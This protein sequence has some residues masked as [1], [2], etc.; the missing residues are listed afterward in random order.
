MK[1]KSILLIVCLT[2]LAACN[3]ADRQQAGGAPTVRVDQARATRDGNA[4]QFPGR[5]T[6]AQEVNASFKVAGTLQRVC[7]DEG[8]HVRAGQL[9]AELDP[10]DYRV[11]LD[12]TEA[13]YAQVKAEAERVMGLYEDGGTTASFY[14]KARYGLQ[15]M[16]AK[17]QN[18]RNQLAYTRIYAPMD[19]YVQKRYMDAGETVGAGMPVVSVMSVKRLEVEVNLPAATYMQRERMEQFEC[20]MDVLPHQTMPLQLVGIRPGANAN[21]LYTMRLALKDELSHQMAPG[22]SV[23]VTI[24]MADSTGRCVSLPATALVRE[25]K[26]TYIY[27]Y[28]A[29][30]RTVVRT[31]VR[32]KTL[33]TDGSA[34]V[35]GDVREGDGVVTVGARHL[36]DGQ[37]VRLLERESETNVG[38][39]L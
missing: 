19:G 14:D 31:P 16:E 39:M 17:L 27:R 37:E 7:V 10:A 26:Q 25:D 9:L 3:G 29:E 38:G 24:H 35:E 6:S 8:D 34:W 1:T 13:E 2:V 30:R 28:N 23:W 32:V 36:T 22:M 11:Q 4:L 12:A 21:Q 33:R 5:V 15:Q 20:S 18:H